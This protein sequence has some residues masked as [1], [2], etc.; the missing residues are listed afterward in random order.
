MAP[1]ASPVLVPT[2]ALTAAFALLNATPANTFPKLAT[3]VCRKLHLASAPF[4]PEEV[5]QLA[6]LFETSAAGVET[7]IQATS[8][9]VEQAAYHTLKPGK[10]EAQLAACG[11]AEAHAAALAQ[12]WAAEAESLVAKLRERPFGAPLAL[13]D[14]QCRQNLIVADSTLSRQQDPSTILEL[15]L[16][17]PAGAAAETL[18]LELDRPALEALFGQ[19]EAVQNG[20]DKLA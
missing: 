8:Y 6:T 20:L 3:R 10:L 7:I 12:V 9:V 18:A 15:K 19:L 11:L 13:A 4:A 17:H 14:V 1:T 16:A 2:A 5:A